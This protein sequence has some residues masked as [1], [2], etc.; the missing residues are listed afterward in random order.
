MTT[1]EALKKA[2]EFERARDAAAY[3]EPS[4]F[5]VEWGAQ[6]ALIVGGVVDGKRTRGRRSRRRRDGDRFIRSCLAK[7]LA[8]W[9]DVP[10]TARSGPSHSAQLAEWLGVSASVV[11]KAWK[12]RP[13][14][15]QLR[16][17]H[18]PPDWADE[19]PAGALRKSR[20]RS[21]PD[22]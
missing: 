18:M 3:L 1:R 14:A 5:I 11:A 22:R 9:S 2:A 10:V 17:A 6:Y 20:T 4:L 8:Q 21:T 16:A 13:T 7:M 19:L 12:T 15:D